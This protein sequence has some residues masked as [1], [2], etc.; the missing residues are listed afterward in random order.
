[1]I[2]AIP[3]LIFALYLQTFK[4]PDIFMLI[5]ACSITLVYFAWIQIYIIKNE[6]LINY[7]KKFNFLKNTLP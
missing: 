5:I 7:V 2:Y 3:M 4:I 1:M 6:L